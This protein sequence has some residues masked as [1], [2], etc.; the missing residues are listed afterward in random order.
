[1]EV[2]FPEKCDA[3]KSGNRLVRGQVNMADEAKFYNPIHS[4]FLKHWF[5]MKLSGVVEK[6][7]TLSVDQS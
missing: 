3:S 4:T 2:F 1:M 5:K 7:W 6:N